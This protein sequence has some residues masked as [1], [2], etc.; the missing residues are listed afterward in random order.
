V[1]SKVYYND[2]DLHACDWMQGLMDHELIAKGTIDNRSIKNVQ[3]DDV[4]GF[5]R[6]HFFAGIAG[7]EY[8]L[9]LAGWPDDRPVWTGS[10]PCQSYSS[11][12]KRKGNDDERD[13][14]PDFFN[15]IREC[16]PATVFG[17][18]VANAIRFGWIDR[19]QADME[20][21]GYAVGF[22]VL[23]A[24]SAGRDHIR[25]RLFW[26]AD[27]ASGRA[28]QN[29]RW[30]REERGHGSISDGMADA[31]HGERRRAGERGPGRTSQGKRDEKS[32]DDQRCGVIGRLADASSRTSERRTGRLLAAEAGISPADGPEHGNRVERLANG[33]EDC[34]LAIPNGRHE[35][36]GQLQ[37]S[38]EQRFESED[39]GTGERMGNAIGI[40]QERRTDGR[41]LFSKRREAAE[42]PARF[43]SGDYDYIPCRDGKTR[44]VE[45]G[46]EPLVDGLPFRLAD[47]RTREGVSRQKVLHG[48]GNA[49]VPQAAVSFV[50]AFLE[51]ENSEI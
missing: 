46:L 34:R 11:A 9:Q 37:R 38:G 18:Q 20:G 22:A 49:I 15:L 23:G 30:L 39:G 5:D 19:L 7:W 51:S 41:I 10:C 2:F 29:Q 4:R 8:A 32:V 25:Q 31:G 44:R 14:W 33:G 12:G 1:K 13:L 3:T 35:C 17:E 48:I 43:P 24:H 21:E 6:V 28:R 36:D 27:A 16:R 45:S 47:G 26:V 42:R 50:R 40:G